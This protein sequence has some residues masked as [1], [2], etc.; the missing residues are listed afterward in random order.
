MHYAKES[1]S[2][3]SS[4]SNEKLKAELGAAGWSGSLAAEADC[5]EAAGGAS[6]EEVAATERAPRLCCTIWSGVSA[7][8]TAPDDTEERCSMA[9]NCCDCETAS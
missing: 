9:S 5:L 6:E 2:T 4:L 3:M 8:A 1:E 7:A